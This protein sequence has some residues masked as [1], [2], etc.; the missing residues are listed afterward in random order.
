VPDELGIQTVLK[1]G[2]KS[3]EHLDG[4]MTLN[5]ERLQEALVATVEGYV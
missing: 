5:E 1:S 2:Q 4:Y 3:I